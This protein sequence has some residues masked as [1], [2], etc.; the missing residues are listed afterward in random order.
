MT[1]PMGRKPYRNPG[2]VDNHP[3]C[4]LVLPRI[5]KNF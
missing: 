1:Q 4:G 5:R 2:K 3:G